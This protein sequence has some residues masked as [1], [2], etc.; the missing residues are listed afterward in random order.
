VVSGAGQPSVSALPEGHPPV[1][2]QAQPAPQVASR[3]RELQQLL[4][5]NPEDL[6]LLVALGNLHFD[7][8]E[9][10][11]ARTWYERALEIG[12]ENPDVITDLAVVYRNLKQP[13]RALEK[14]DRAIGL[15]PDH[16]Q[17]WHN[18]VVILHFDL[19]RHD[20]AVRALDRLKE[21]RRSNPDVPDLSSLEQQSRGG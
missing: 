5:Q 11:D 18:K 14:L 6:R 21:I 16:W 8:G 3:S 4:E 2:E 7:A 20:E 17:A 1:P 12:T 10:P 19:H 15:A 13:E 9:W